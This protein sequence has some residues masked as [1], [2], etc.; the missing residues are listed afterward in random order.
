MARSSSFHPMHF[1][2]KSMDPKQLS[3]TRT[4]LEQSFLT[5]HIRYPLH[6]EKS[7]EFLSNEKILLIGNEGRADPGFLCFLPRKPVQFLKCRLDTGFYVRLRVES[8]LFQDG[9]VFIASHHLNTITVQDCWMWQGENLTK[10]PYSKRFS[11]VSKFISSYIIQDPRLSGFEVQAATHYQLDSFQTLV[12]SQDYASIDFIPEN[13]RRRRLFYRMETSAPP[14][15]VSKSAPKIVAQKPVPKPVAQ[16]YHHTGPLI[17]FAKNIQGLPDTFDLFGSDKV[18]IGEAAVQEEEI[19]IE[20]SRQIQKTP[21]LLVVVE[22]NSF[23]DAFEIKGL[24]P[25]GSKVLPSGVFKKGSAKTQQ[26]AASALD[27]FEA[28]ED[29]DE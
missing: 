12:D 29:S 3:E 27:T 25:S 21:S 13:S 20:L 10:L 16:V 22:W 14:N 19:S 9:T 26:A 4:F 28:S 24:A 18:H 6:I 8:S 7:E 15:S 11:Y 5:T 17:A 2:M 1:E 23:L